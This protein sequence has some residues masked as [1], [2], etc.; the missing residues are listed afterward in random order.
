MRRKFLSIMKFDIVSLA[1]ENQKRM[2]AEKKIGNNKVGSSSKV[3]FNNE[4]G[5][6]T[7]I[8]TPLSPNRSA[9]DSPQNT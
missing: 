6:Q 3:H 5:N 2:D 7:Y 4:F 9:K 1:K 8:S